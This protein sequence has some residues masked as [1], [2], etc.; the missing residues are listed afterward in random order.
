MAFKDRLTE[1]EFNVAVL[2]RLNLYRPKTSRR[3]AGYSSSGYATPKSLFTSSR[4]VSPADGGANGGG[5][6]GGEKRNPQGFIVKSR[7]NGG[8]STPASSS[9]AA[10]TGAAAAERDAAADDGLSAGEY[11]GSHSY[12]P[13]LTDPDEE[14]KTAG[15]S[16]SFGRFAG[17]VGKG[18][19]KVALHD[20]RNIK[21]KQGQT[22][23]GDLVNTLTSAKVAK[24]RLFL[25]AARSKIS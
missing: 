20:A 1:I 5:S 10:L 8:R 17:H 2:D 18:V 19:R 23:N 15:T 3:S 11:A 6:A 25:H 24:V 13:R 16:S 7:T 4:K 9:S 12:P 21:G 22:E 14:E